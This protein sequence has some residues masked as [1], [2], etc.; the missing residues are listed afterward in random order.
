MKKCVI[1]I[2]LVSVVSAGFAG[3]KLRTKR[4]FLRKIKEQ[5]QTIAELENQVSKLKSQIESWRASYINLQIF[6][7]ENSLTVPTELKLKVDGKDNRY[8]KK[9][10]EINSIGYIKSARIIDVANENEALIEIG[11]WTPS[12]E[13]GGRKVGSAVTWTKGDRPSPPPSN[14]RT[15]KF[16]KHKLWLTGIST[17]NFA[18]DESVKLNQNFI[19]TGKHT[20]KTANGGQNTVFKIKPIN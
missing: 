3:D 18:S 14:P 16:P 1:I 10:C 17:R 19:I 8:F 15:P 13:T 5:E 11:N 4:D 2:L 12:T 9:N 7:S 20:Y 6:C